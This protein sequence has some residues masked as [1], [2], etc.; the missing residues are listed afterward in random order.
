MRKRP[1]KAPTVYRIVMN[2]RTCPFDSRMCSIVNTSDCQMNE[3]KGEPINLFYPMNVL[4]DLDS[5]GP[6]TSSA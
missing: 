3:F 5:S 2:L 1:L 6:R 4:V